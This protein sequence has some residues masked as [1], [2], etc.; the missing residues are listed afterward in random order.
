MIGRFGLGD[1]DKEIRM[2]AQDTAVPNMLGSY[3]A[4]AAELVPDAPGPMSYRSAH[5][6]DAMSWRTAL[7][8]KF[9]ELSGLDFVQRP[10]RLHS[11]VIQSGT[12]DGLHFELLEWNVGYGP[13]TRSVFLKPADARGRLPAIIAFHDHGGVKHIGWQ[14]IAQIQDDCNQ[15]VSSFRKEYYGNRPWANELA[16]R[17]YAVLVPDAFLFGSRRINPSELP[18]Y[19]ATRLLSQSEASELRPEDRN[20][21]RDYT[22]DLPKT[23]EPSA[24]EISTYNHFASQCEGTI[25]KSL[26]AAG[27]TW[28]AVFLGDDLTALDYLVSRPDVDP[29]RVGCGGLSGGGLRTNYLAGMDDRIA[30]SVTAGFMTTWTDLV[31]HTSHTHTWMTYVPGL[32]R[33][34][35]YPEVLGMRAP[36]PSLVQATT[37]D[38]LFTLSYVRRAETILSEVYACHGQQDGF[39]MEYYPG[40][41]KFDRDM[42]NQAFEWFDTWLR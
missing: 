17:G 40:P 38:P 26:F 9:A 6:E 24:A 8:A 16:H 13:P 15:F 11:H 31:L 12:Y 1:K 27:I 36:L 35:D 34:I 39:R 3:G 5:R 20:D 10:L 28:P 41:H 33:Y 14:K 29:S 30:C 2:E 7:R 37:E 42:Q 21:S 32:P 25:A 22:Y 23:G 18:G 19:V 4:W